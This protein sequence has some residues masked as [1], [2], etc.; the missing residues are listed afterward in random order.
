MQNP[1]QLKL[2]FFIKKL[3]FIFSAILFLGINS[4]VYAQIYVDADAFGT[5]DG[6]SWDNAYN[7]LQDALANASGSDEIWIAEGTYYPDEGA[8][9]TQGNRS[10]S[11]YIP[12]TKDGLKIYGG[13]SGS[14][15]SL[16]QRNLAANKTI[17]SG[18]I[19]QN[20]SFSE[21]SYHVVFLIGL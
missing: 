9:Q 21:N 18:D 11:F 16:E 2:Y 5:N 13:F 12:N 1:V 7:H 10:A 20:N 19:D 14:E 17:L 15:S 3:F 6:T 8:N 4:N